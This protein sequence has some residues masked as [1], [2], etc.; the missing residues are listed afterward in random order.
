MKNL[1]L[2]KVIVL[3]SCV[4]LPVGYWYCTGIEAEIVACKKAVAEATRQGGTLEQ[5]GGLQKKVELVV[6][7]RLSTSD[8]TNQPRIYFERQILAAAAGQ[9]LNSNDFGLSDPREEPAVLANQRQRAA[10]YVLTVDWKR[11]DLFVRL[12]FIYAVLF[13]CESG[14]RAGGGATQSIWKLRELELQNATD[15]RLISGFR[16]P[17]AELQDS[18]TIRKM[19]FARREPKKK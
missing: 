4:L 10:D 13:N 15:D 14:A 1:D 7:N 19:S 2:Y 12:S 18:W 3:L 6:Q 16:T 11:K 17:P 5:I 9:G 8:A